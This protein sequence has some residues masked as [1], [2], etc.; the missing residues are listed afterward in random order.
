MLKDLLKCKFRENKTEVPGKQLVFLH[1]S[2]G[3]KL[4][5]FSHG[6]KLVAKN[7]LQ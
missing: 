5:L 7:I 2:N 4:M 3:R 1:R 6:S